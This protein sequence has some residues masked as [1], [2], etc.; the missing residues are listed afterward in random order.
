MA[1]IKELYKILEEILNQN[2]N[3]SRKSQIYCEIDLYRSR[4]MQMND[5]YLKSVFKILEDEG[6]VNY[7]AEFTNHGEFHG[8][9]LYLEKKSS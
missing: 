6:I 4:Y 7:Y 8:I 3:L 2:T 5:Y 1:T 9:Y